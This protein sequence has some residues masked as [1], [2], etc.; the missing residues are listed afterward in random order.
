MFQFPGLPPRVLCIQTQVSRYQPGGVAPFGHPRITACWQL[1]AAYRSHPRPSSA[2]GAKAST[3]RPYSLGIPIARSRPLPSRQD[4][5]RSSASNGCRLSPLTHLH[6][7]ALVQVHLRLIACRRAHRPS[8]PCSRPQPASLATPIRDDKNAA[9]PER[10][11]SNRR[12]PSIPMDMLA[13]FCLLRA[14]AVFCACI[15]YNCPDGPVIPDLRLGSRCTRGAVA[16]RLID[17]L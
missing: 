1:P 6:Y 16:A 14:R 13:S 9:R 7:S 4:L 3:V 11:G 17:S 15:S 12:G 8:G 2:L 5:A 10:F